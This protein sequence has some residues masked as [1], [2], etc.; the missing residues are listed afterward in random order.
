MNSKKFLA[1]VLVAI[2]LAQPSSAGPTGWIVGGVIGAAVGVVVAPVAA[3]VALGAMGFT[4]TGIAAGSVGA[5]MMSTV[6]TT[7][8]GGAPMA[9][10]VG[11][12]Q[13]AGAA[14]VAGATTGFSVGS[15][16]GMFFGL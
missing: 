14:G 6:A 3:T 16:I 1:V 10:T 9:Y 8:G 4:S 11:I 12:L 5:G 13:S 2:L 7:L 15:K